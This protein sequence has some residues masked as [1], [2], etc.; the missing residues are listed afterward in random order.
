MAQSPFAFY[1]GAAAVMAADLAYRLR[2]TSFITLRLSVRRAS[3]HSET[4]R[5][6]HRTPV[7]AHTGGEGNAGRADAVG[8]HEKDRSRDIGF[9]ELGTK[10]ATKPPPTTSVWTPIRQAPPSCASTTG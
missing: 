9:G 5:I 8:G 2:R 7:A 10:T 4:L 3:T 1:R 6:Q